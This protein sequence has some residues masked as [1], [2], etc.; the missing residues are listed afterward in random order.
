MRPR[1]QRTDDLG[2]TGQLRRDHNTRGTPWAPS[3]RWGP[4]IIDWRTDRCSGLTSSWAAGWEVFTHETCGSRHE[5]SAVTSR[6]MRGLTAWS[7]ETSWRHE[8]AATPSL[9]NQQPAAAKVLAAMLDRLHLN[10]SGPVR[11]DHSCASPSTANYPPRAEPTIASSL[12]K[13]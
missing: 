3:P 2:Q 11:S 8:G 13:A 4:D 5:F 7:N 9:L 6:F 1:A 10:Y 12:S